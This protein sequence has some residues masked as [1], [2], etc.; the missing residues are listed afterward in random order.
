MLIDQR[1][2][3]PCKKSGRS[4]ESVQRGLSEWWGRVKRMARK[5]EDIDFVGPGKCCWNGDRG[6][7]K[8]CC[9]SDQGR[10]HWRDKSY[11]LLDIAK[12]LR[13]NSKHTNFPVGLEEKFKC[14]S[15]SR[16]CWEQAFLMQ[17]LLR[18]RFDILFSSYSSNQ[19]NI[20][21]HL[22]VC[23]IAKTR[24][25]FSKISRASGIVELTRISP[26]LLSLCTISPDVYWINGLKLNMS[27]SVCVRALSQGLPW[28][29]HCVKEVS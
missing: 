14:G 26:F 22:P 11:L 24:S 28:Y 16:V 7:R 2:K 4:R 10:T 25:A 12:K 6:K 20:L 9:A 3:C 8:L 19:F 23:Y 15:S 18:N 1:L 29:K 13:Q 27:I 21:K 5:V 17:S